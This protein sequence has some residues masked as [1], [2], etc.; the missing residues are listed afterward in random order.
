MNQLNMEENDDRL[1]WGLVIEQGKQ[2]KQTPKFSFHVSMA[3]LDLKSVTNNEPVTLNVEVDGSDF[4]LCN[5]NKNQSQ[6][7]LDLIFNE[8]EKIKFYSTGAGNIHLTGYTMPDE[9]LGDMLDDEEFSDED[10]SVDLEMDKSLKRKNTETI[11]LA[12]KDAKKMK[13]AVEVKAN[14]VVKPQQPKIVDV[15]PKQLIAQKKENKPQQD[16]KQQKNKQAQKKDL[17][18]KKS[19]EDS[20]DDDDDLSIDGDDDSVDM[21][22]FKSMMDDED[23][24][25]DD[26]DLEDSDLDSDEDDVAKLKDIKAK[27]QQAKPQQQNASIQKNKQPQQQQNQN[28]QK[29]KNNWQNNKTP[30]NKNQNS[31]QNKQNSQQKH[32]PTP[33]HKGQ[34]NSGKKQGT[35]FQHNKNKSFGSHNKQAKKAFN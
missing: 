2:Y 15:D 4:I 21:A 8:G 28:K 3:V 13:V 7:H 17:L 11:K 9:G 6:S 16:Q 33:F 19:A 30:Q 14:G 27:Q 12:G 5:L 25:V 26:D 29:Q 34:N 31:P 32:Q 24:E 10:E 18:T 35:P 1:F 23:S 20:D 22:N